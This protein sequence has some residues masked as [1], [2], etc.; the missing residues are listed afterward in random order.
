MDIW[1]T[2]W[3]STGYYWTVVPVSATSSRAFTTALV[4]GAAQGATTIIV[5]SLGLQ[6][7]DSISIGAGGPTEEANSVAS[8]N[9]S[10]VTLGSTLQ[11]N[12]GAGEVVVR[13]SS[14][15]Y[16]ETELWQD[17]C[18][19]G[20][21]ARFGKISQP[22]V[23]G[24]AQAVHLRPHDERNGHGGR[25]DAHVLRRSRRSPGSRRSARTSTRSS[26]AAPTTR[27]SRR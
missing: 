11:K 4:S 13:N 12:H 24:G 21:V 3:P 7:G 14:L 26:G 22:V 15:E 16:R 6:A 8:V 17:A 23:T 25:Y 18:T 1:D 9:G 27:S 19:S 2:D 20:R 10:V 5:S